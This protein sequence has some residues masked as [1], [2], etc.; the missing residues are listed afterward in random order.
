MHRRVA[1]KGIIISIK[2]TRV[3]MLVEVVGG[4]G[5][6]GFTSTH[7]RRASDAD[8]AGAL[9]LVFSALSWSTK[10]ADEKRTYDYARLQIL[11]AFANGGCADCINGLDCGSI[12]RDLCISTFKETAIN[13]TSAD[14]CNNWHY[15]KNPYLA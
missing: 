4:R 6:G 15:P 1:A 9:L 5:Q 14:T 13:K 8:C 12:D 7:H 10:L 11:A 2:L 3:F